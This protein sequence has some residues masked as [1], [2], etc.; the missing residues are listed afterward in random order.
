MR[1]KNYWKSGIPLSVDVCTGPSLLK[2]ISFPPLELSYS[3]ARVTAIFCYGFYHDTASQYS[4]YRNCCRRVKLQNGVWSHFKNST[5]LFKLSSKTL[6]KCNILGTWAP[7]SFWERL[8]S[9]SRSKALSSNFFESWTSNFGCSTPPLIY[10]VTPRSSCIFMHCSINQPT[11]LL[12][13]H[14]SEKAL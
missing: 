8:S 12:V 5:T 1:L 7:F 2:N 3:L 13:N 10:C 14:H 6:T 9:K 11:K 4:I